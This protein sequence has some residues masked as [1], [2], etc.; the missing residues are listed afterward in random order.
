MKRRV[1]QKATEQAAY[2]FKVP[3]YEV[4]RMKGSEQ[5][6]G[7]VGRSASRPHTHRLHS[8]CPC[9]HFSQSALCTLH[10][11]YTSALYLHSE[12]AYAVG[13]GGEGDE[14]RRVGA[15]AS[16]G[17][18]DDVNVV[19]PHQTHPS[20]EQQDHKEQQGL[21]RRE[22]AKERER[23]LLRP[24]ACRRCLPVCLSRRALL[25]LSAQ[26][27]L[28]GRCPS[29]PGCRVPRRRIS[30]SEISTSTA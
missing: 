14:H 27:L 3:S 11:I 18:H 15:A 30:T 21:P 29:T 13:G 1:G 17:R 9:M 22:G 6:A 12:A 23:R 20:A 16:L 28:P 2:A 5:A 4:A 25:L 8:H 19:Y 26:E 7:A 24:L 10:S